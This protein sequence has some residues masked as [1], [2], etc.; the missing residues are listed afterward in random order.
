MSKAS[1][2]EIVKGRYE[3]W[4][5]EKLIPYEKN[6]KVHDKH[7]VARIA[8]S[9]KNSGWSTRIEVDKDGV[10]IAGHGRRLA[11]LELK[12]SHVPVHVRD[13]LSPAEIKA[14][15]LADNKTAEGRIDTSLLEEELRELAELNM[16]MGD[17][18]DERELEFLSEDL[19]E[20]D[21]GSISDDIS[22]EVEENS[23]RTEKH[24]EEHDQKQTSVAEALGFAKINGEQRRSINTF[25][26]FVEGV[27]GLKGAE[28]L[29]RYSNDVID[30]DEKSVTDE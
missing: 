16:D 2:K 6:A 15:R 23:E 9:I 3:I 22:G 29:A 8:A 10:I 19:G 4:P 27:T 13:D 26:I 25:M 30:A 5:V 21:M 14:H 28:A 1:E 7:Q 18:F 12:H 20:I 11:A 17:Y 24:V